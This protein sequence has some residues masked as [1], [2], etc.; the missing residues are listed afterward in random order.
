MTY[1][2]RTHKQDHLFST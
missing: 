2:H 1:E